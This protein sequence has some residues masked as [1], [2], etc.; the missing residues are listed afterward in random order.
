MF[1]KGGSGDK[2]NIKIKADN[3][4]TTTP[5]TVTVDVVHGMPQ[6]TAKLSHIAPIEA[7]ARGKPPDAREYNTG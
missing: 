2:I 6:H 4:A 5:P 7:K 1:K 3:V